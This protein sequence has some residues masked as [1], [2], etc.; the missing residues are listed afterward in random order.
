MQE[1]LNLVWEH[2]LPALDGATVPDAVAPKA[3]EILPPSGPAPAGGDGRTYR[4]EPNQ[5][6]LV[7]A[8]L[9]PDGT[10]TF[11]VE[12][13]SVTSPAESAQGP[14]YDVVCRPGDWREAAHGSS[15]GRLLTSAYGDGDAFVATLRYVATPYVVTLTCRPEG[16]ALIVDYRFNVGF[17]P[18]T[19]T[20]TA[21]A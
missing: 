16:D 6:G 19:V 7:A 17:G 13:A 14:R 15:D 4:F 2:V 5:A 8:R 18:S 10:G 21:H 20:L 12:R 3:L 9:A 11:T 1:V